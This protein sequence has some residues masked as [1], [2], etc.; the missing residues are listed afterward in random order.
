MPKTRE[1]WVT[2]AAEKSEPGGFR[3]S[4]VVARVQNETPGVRRHWGE[5]MHM[6]LDKALKMEKKGLVKIID[7]LG[8]DREGN[9][10]PASQGG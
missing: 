2:L 8:V 3:S 9:P 7:V 6:S 1:E 4:E 10:M 5:Q